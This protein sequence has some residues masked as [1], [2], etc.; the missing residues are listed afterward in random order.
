MKVIE[1][2]ASQWEGLAYML[3]FSSTIV[4]TIE[5][6]SAKDCIA[7]CTEVLHQ[8]VGGA[9]GTRQ[10]VSWAT[11]IECLRDCDFTVLASD[12]ESALL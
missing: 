4:K 10:P 2:V 9:E 8:W 12:L 5:R 3:Q 7:A 1:E 6:D 11:L